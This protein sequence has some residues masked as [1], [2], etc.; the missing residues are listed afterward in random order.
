MLRT[1]LFEIADQRGIRYAWMAD[2]L[3]YT[4]EYLSRIKHGVAPIT[5]EFQR[6]ACALFPDVQPGTL[7]FD[8]DGGEFHHSVDKVAI[9]GD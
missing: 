6:R 1:R 4:R 8:D 7:F 9:A 3:G 5:D 2:Q